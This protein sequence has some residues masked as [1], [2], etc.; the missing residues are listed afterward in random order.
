M[1]ATMWMCCTM[2]VLMGVGG[3]WGHG[4]LVDPPSRAS[5]WR[6]GWNTPV[7]YDDNEGFCGG[8]NHQYQSQGGKCGICGDAWDENPRPH[9]AGGKYA[10]G[11]I[12]MQYA[13]GQ[14]V[15]IQVDITANHKGYIEFKICPNNN[16][17]VEATQDCLDQHPLYL[18]DGSGLKYQVPYYIGIHLIQVRLPPDVT[19]SQC[20]LQWR[21]V[22]GNNWGV[23]EDGTGQ[24]GCGPQEEFRSCADVAISGQQP[25]W[26]S[27]S[28][29]E[30]TVNVTE[31]SH[32]GSHTWHTTEQPP[33][34]PPP[35][36]TT[37]QT[38][39]Q[40]IP[41]GSNPPTEAETSTQPSGCYA[42]GIWQSL[43]NMDMWC[44]INCHNTPPYC[45]P[46]HCI[47][48]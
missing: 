11:A 31:D 5:A 43:H 29:T 9:E 16:P 48:Y 8:F 17:S 20:V 35:F 19:C 12:V 41:T 26:T 32:T 14:V 45:P 25:T 46:T 30:G 2:L 28:I 23:C 3:C 27:G 6:F 39:G 37:S 47:C 10:T 33:A 34:T 13:V 42:V 4:R 7:D 38:S 18:A 44:S 21:Y 40:P 15:D 24:L 36:H 1:A 22:A